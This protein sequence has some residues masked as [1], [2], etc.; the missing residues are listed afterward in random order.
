MKSYWRAVF[1]LTLALR[2]RFLR[3]RTSLFFTFLFPLIFL[4]I[5]G[6]IFGNNSVS[7]KVAVINNSSST[8]AN[9]FVKS[10]KS[11][12]TFNVSDTSGL[13]QAKT[14]MSH[15]ELDSIIELPTQFG[16][17]NQQGV[18]SGTLNVYSQKGS[19][20]SGQAVAAI[21][22]QILDGV[23]K[24]FG[25][26]DAALKVSQV[27]TAEV[28]ASTFDYTFS[29]LLGFSLMSMGIFGLANAMPSEKEK[30]SYRRLRAAPFKASQ[31]VLANA[32]HYLQV[33]L[34]SVAM[35]MIVGISVFHFNM[36]GDWF[37]FSVFAVVSAV[38]VIGFGLVVGALASNDSQ[39]APIANLVSFPMMFLSGAF[40]PRFAFPEWLQ[41][42]SAFIPL[43]SVID[44]FRLIMTEH[45]SL[46][47]VGPQLGIMIAWIVAAYFIAM[48]FFHWGETS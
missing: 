19:E 18:P 9:E 33:T 31:L 4:F 41:T 46:I 21:T 39:S 25:R 26:P 1:G 8:F 44:G 23:N 2:R 16:Q 7:F 20:Q 22:Q 17:A 27:S 5:F 12:N 47:S 43:T 24:Q 11:N 13:E 36:R 6:T 38:M 45:A 42:V 3:D 35:M 30:G 34:M 15:S 10:I 29:G 32:L 28:G 37:T 14:S 48:R 40:F